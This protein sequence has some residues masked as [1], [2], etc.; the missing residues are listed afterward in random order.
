MSVSLKRKLLLHLDSNL[1]YRFV[2]HVAYNT[3]R[4]SP[5]KQLLART[6]IIL[7]T[8]SLAGF[9]CRVFI[10]EATS[11]GLVTERT[12]SIV[13]SLVLSRATERK[14]KYETEGIIGINM[15]C[16]HL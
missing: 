11:L 8:D 4:F 7:S 9:F 10:L 12:T 1:I 6:W 3:F 5:T 16:I 15:T 14:W 13:S 2:F